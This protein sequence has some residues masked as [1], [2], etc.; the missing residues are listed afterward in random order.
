[1]TNNGEGWS[2]EFISESL[3][4]QHSNDPLQL[5]QLIENNVQDKINFLKEEVAKEKINS[6]YYFSKDF[7]IN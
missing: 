3:F 2:F 1:M 6:G 7:K 4:Q 5:V